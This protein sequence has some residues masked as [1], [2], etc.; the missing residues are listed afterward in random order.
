MEV[1]EVALLRD[2]LVDDLLRHVLQ[3]QVQAGVDAIAIA[4]AGLDV[5]AAGQRLEDIVDEVGSL[6][7][8]RGGEDLELFGVGDLG[9]RR[10]DGLFAHHPGQDLR[11]SLLGRDEVRQR[12]VLAGRLRQAGQHGGLP[13]RQVVGIGLEIT[14]SRR[15]DPVRL[16]AVIDGVEVHLEN[17]ILGELTVELDGED[18]FLELALQ[19]R[20]G[21][22]P[23]IELLHQ[24]LTD[25]AATLRHVLMVE[26]GDGGAEDA[27]HVDAAVLIE[28]AVLGCQCGLHDPGR[29]VAERDDDSMVALL[30]DIGEQRPMAIVNQGVLLEISVDDVADRG[31]RSNGLSRDRR[32]GQDRDHQED[33]QTEDQGAPDIGAR[34][35]APAMN[36]AMRPAPGG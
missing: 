14:A 29:D 23:D 28:G 25:R 15:L 2:L 7:L 12:V 33:H 35:L 16:A 30:A 11:L 17:L 19:G 10:A 5:V 1:V 34:A 6:E 31:Q 20:R 27:A 24:L 26:V 36:L 3:V 8:G 21:I 9:L 4:I 32:H 13:E 18:G 22:R